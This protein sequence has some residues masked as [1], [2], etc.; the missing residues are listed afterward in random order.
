MSER[1]V[2]SLS[3]PER[4][5]YSITPTPIHKLHRVSSELGVN[6]FVKRD[7]LTGFVLGGN[8]VRKLDYLFADA[9]SQGA[10][11]VISCG[12]VQSNHCRAVAAVA[13]QMG[14]ACVL[15]LRGERP[16]E[17]KAN[18]LLDYLMGA[19]I[20]YVTDEEYERREEFRLRIEAEFRT[21]G[22]KAY[23]IPEG[24]SNPLGTLGYVEAWSEL[25]SQ[26]GNADPVFG[27]LVPKSFDSI[28]VANGS[29][30]T[31]CGLVLGKILEKA[32]STRVVGV[33]VCYD[34]KETF[35]LVKDLLWK[36][37]VQQKLGLSFLASDIELLD[38]FI[39]E[40]YAKN[41][42]DEFKFFAKIA[43]LEGLLLDP[44]YSGKAFLGLYKTLQRDKNFFGENVLFIHTGGGFGN[45]K[46]SK[47]WTDAL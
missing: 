19:D 27:D 38:G 7:D 47:E 33:N 2:G 29:G 23:Y 43:R 12:G 1:Q 24:G 18:L 9:K 25:V 30:G 44:T 39:G 11:A 45:F 26:C 15:I 35:N 28:V 3:L 14:L 5:R 16:A 20:I 31:Q 32:D 40:G 13:A 6:I 36:T 37:M 21:R 17:L 22:G 10:S 42:P 46:Y 8:K 34:K 41:T 4:L